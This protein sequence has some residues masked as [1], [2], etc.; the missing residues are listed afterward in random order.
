MVEHSACE[1]VA[2]VALVEGMGLWYH[3]RF[4]RDG[5]DELGGLHFCGG[6]N[7]FDRGF[8]AEM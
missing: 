3:F 5:G 7:F 4:G 1:V 8:T 2:K 6:C